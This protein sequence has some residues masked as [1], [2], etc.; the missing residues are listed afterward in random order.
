MTFTNYFHRECILYHVF[1]RSLC[2]LVVGQLAFWYYN[3]FNC[4]NREHIAYKAKLYVY[5][6]CLLHSQIFVIWLITGRFADPCYRLLRAQI[7]QLQVENCLYSL[8]F[9]Y[10][11][12]SNLIGIYIFWVLSIYQRFLISSLK[13]YPSFMVKK[14]G[15]QNISQMFWLSKIVNLRAKIQTQVWLIPE[16][17][18]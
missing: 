16:P 7:R 11:T 6:L 15:I 12:S 13:F 17:K 9:L 4:G 8:F 5:C 2:S 10:I 1:Q 18:L 3:E 14:T